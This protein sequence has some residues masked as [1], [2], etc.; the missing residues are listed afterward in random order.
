MKN[1]AI[2]GVVR[3]LLTIGAGALASRGV[4]GESEVEITVGSVIAILSVVWSIF[5]KKAQ[6]KKLEAAQG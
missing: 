5:D 6:A 3:H 4:I 1:P 2:L